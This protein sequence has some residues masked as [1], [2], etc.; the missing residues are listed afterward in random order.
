MSNKP[1]R[2]ERFRKFENLRLEIMDVAVTEPFQQAVMSYLALIEA[3]IF[4]LVEMKNEEMEFVDAI[5]KAQKEIK[6][7]EQKPYTTGIMPCGKE[8]KDENSKD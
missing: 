2:Q 5:E 7:S 3:D 8:T 1:S 6:Q 4:M